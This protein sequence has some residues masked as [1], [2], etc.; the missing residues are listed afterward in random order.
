MAI[1]GGA[2]LFLSVLS[3]VVGNKYY[4]P[5][6]IAHGMA[7]LVF[8]YVGN[9]VHLM[10]VDKRKCKSWFLLNALNQKDSLVYYKSEVSASLIHS[11]TI[12]SKEEKLNA[13]RQ[14]SEHLLIDSINTINKKKSWEK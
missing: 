12:I 13:I 7:A 6:Y 9:L 4:V 2:I 10:N 1:R 3:V 5:F 8:Y 14:K 11:D